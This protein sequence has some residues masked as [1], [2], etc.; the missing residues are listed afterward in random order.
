MRFAFVCAM[1]AACSAPSAEHVGK[2]AAAASTGALVLN[3]MA[4]PKSIYFGNPLSVWAIV[5]S[6]GVTVHEDVT[7]TMVVTGSVD[8]SKYQFF[9]YDPT[10]ACTQ[11]V[12][13]SITVTC[14]ADSVQAKDGLSFDLMPRVAGVVSLDVKAT[15]GGV[16][17]GSFHSDTQVVTAAGADVGVHASGG[18][19][20]QLGQVIDV[21][22][23]AFDNG[24]LASTDTVLTLAINGPGKFVSAPPGKD[25]PPAAG[26]TFTDTTATCPLG[27]LQAYGASTIHAFVQTTGVGYL[28][29]DGAVTANEADP[30]TYNNY[31][32][33]SFNVFRPVVADLSVAMSAQPDPTVFNKPLTYTIVVTNHGPDTAS[34]PSL[35]DSFP[36]ELEFQSVTTSQGGCKGGEKGI[37]GCSFGPLA[38]G[39]SAT[40]TLVL[41]PTEGGTVSNTVSVKNYAWSE[42]DPDLSNDSA[43][44]TTLVRGPNTPVN[45]TSNVQSFEASHFAWVPCVNDYVALSGTVHYGTHTLANDAAGRYRYESRDDTQEVVATGYASGITYGSNSVTKT[46]LSFTGGIPASFDYAE[47]Y[48]L[49]AQGAAPDLTVHTMNHVTFAADGTP[50]V[51]VTKYAYECK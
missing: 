45:V 36:A 46:V 44:T 10:W 37:L 4:M 21:P 15:E 33:A 9:G 20:V 38:A 16:E 11:T 27:T 31:A 6:D 47:E 43:T 29:V 12:G 42:T 18:G 28:G 5:A 3:V 30:M 25:P 24:P 23:T 32:S 35:Y 41:T 19:D 51:Q 34:I 7:L 48:Q 13:K 8:Q 22:F 49:V 14:H 2:N 50:K 26:C 17:I 40:V 1:T 39:A